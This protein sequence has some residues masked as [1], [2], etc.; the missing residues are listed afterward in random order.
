MGYP[1]SA[2]VD[3]TVRDMVIALEDCVLF[4]NNQIITQSPPLY[5]PK[6]TAEPLPARPASKGVRNY[7]LQVV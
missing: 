5:T 1:F 6:P 7:S 4:G 2:P 3:R